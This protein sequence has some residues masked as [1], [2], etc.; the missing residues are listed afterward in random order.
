MRMVETGHR[1]WDERSE[2]HLPRQEDRNDTIAAEAVRSAKVPLPQQSVPPA[3][4]DS[5]SG[6]SRPLRL[7]LVLRWP[8]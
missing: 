3:L 5:S 1:G 8:R 2:P 4:A 6:L 7:L